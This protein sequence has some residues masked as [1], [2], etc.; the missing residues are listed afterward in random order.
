[1]NSRAQC[2]CLEKP[3]KLQLNLVPSYRDYCQLGT[4]DHRERGVLK[5]QGEVLAL[6][7][8]GVTVTSVCVYVCVF[9]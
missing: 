8:F 3:S 1:M 6:G 5:G 2:P 7:E 4:P 9:V